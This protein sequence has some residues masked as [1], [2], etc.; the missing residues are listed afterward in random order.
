MI[1]LIE[2]LCRGASHEV[3]NAGFVELFCMAFPSERIVYCAEKTQIDCVRNVLGE[4]LSDTAQIE[5]RPIDWPRNW[6]WWGAL[7]G[8]FKLQGLARSVGNRD[9]IKIVFLSFDNIILSLVKVL[10]D[11]KISPVFPVLLVVHGILEQCNT[12]GLSKCQ[13]NPR[14]KGVGKKHL[15]DAF[16]KLLIIARKHRSSPLLMVRTTGQ[17]ATNG[18][19]NFISQK[20]NSIHKKM[21]PSFCINLK[22]NKSNNFIYIALSEHILTTAKRID[23]LKDLPWRTIPLPRKM[24]ESRVPHTNS[25]RVI[26]SVF[27]YGLPISLEEI[28]MHLQ[29][30]DINAPYEIRL[31]G[32]MP[33][34][35]R[36]YRNVLGPS[37]PGKIS[38][39][40]MDTMNQPVHYQLILYPED[41][42]QLSA[43]GS[44]FEA[45]CCSKP[46]I[47]LNNPCIN[48]YNSDRLPIGYCER[49]LKSIAQRMIDI[50][51]NNLHQTEQYQ[52]FHQ[53]IKTLQRQYS[54]RANSDRLSDIYRAKSYSSSPGRVL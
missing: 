41:S 45:I 36:H 29:E 10:F 40:E 50:I 37:K 28:L 49:D 38:R 25:E 23:Y 17:R 53:N 26:F 47:H 33:S 6:I 13:I 20:F 52:E 39:K 8:Y 35:L 21:V 2:P 32:N 34:K 19:S 7:K 5:W 42:Y 9:D 1:I 27:G 3:F 18:L 46:I 48:Y 11:N 4:T 16:R 31:I 24:I 14:D 44:I 22:P 43:S 12:L 15:I 30:K 54:G 51:Q